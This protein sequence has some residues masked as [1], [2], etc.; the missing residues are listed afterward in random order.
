MQ[1][2]GKLAKVRVLSISVLLGLATLTAVSPPAAAVT[3][4]DVIMQY[5][6]SVYLYSTDIYRPAIAKDFVARSNLRWAHDQ[7]CADHQLASRGNVDIAKLGNGGYRHQTANSWPVCAHNDQW[8]TT[9]AYTRPRSGVVS[10]EGFFL[11]LDNAARRGVGRTA[12]VFYEY[13]A[14]QFVT[15]WFFY[16]FNDAI[17]TVADH[18][19]DWERVTVRLDAYNHATQV[20]YFIHSGYCTLPWSGVASVNSHPVAYSALGTHASYPTGGG[21]DLDRTDQGPSWSTWNNLLN[22]RDQPWYRYGGAWGEVGETSESTGPVGPSAYKAPAP[23]DWN[24]PC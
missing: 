8:Y 5:A 1:S 6:P 2:S 19:G 13:Q 15:Y 14:H 3:D 10:G 18:E 17:T 23:S 11:D 4:L 16:A 7:S 22:V 20:A 24:K 12:P 21:H 9:T